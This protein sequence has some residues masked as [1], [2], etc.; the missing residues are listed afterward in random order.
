MNNANTPLLKGAKE[1]ESVASEE[2][3][4][5]PEPVSDALSKSDILRKRNSCWER[6]KKQWIQLMLTLIIFVL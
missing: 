2:V 1:S 4:E 5:T 6:Y 3:Q